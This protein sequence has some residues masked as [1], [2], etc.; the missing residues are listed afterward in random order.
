MTV[1][2]ER[3]AVSVR[4]H[5]AVAEVTLVDVGRRNSCNPVLVDQLARACERLRQDRSV[6]V[7]VLRA[8]GPVFSAGGDVDSLLEPSGDPT[9]VY[10]GFAALAALPVP[11]V[12]AVHAPVI[13]AGVNFLLA[14]DVVVAAESVTFDIRFLDIGIHPGGGYLTRMQ[15]RI[16][17]QGTAAL[18]LFG[19]RIT[20][21]EAQRC[22]LV[23]RT[24]PDADLDE[25]VRGLTSRVAARD[26]ELLR[27]TKATLALGGALS[28][29]RTAGEVEQI[30]QD[31]SQRQPAYLEGVERLRARVRPGS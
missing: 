24:V 4:V 26:R 27:R 9:A 22:G 21:E 1:D 25:T 18:V 28:V 16:G 12:A 30:A 29:G 23:W 8:E 7:V 10:R 13:G 14:C 6:H 15:E 17:R 19:D 11:V 20:A 2:G 3:T 5:D 31:W